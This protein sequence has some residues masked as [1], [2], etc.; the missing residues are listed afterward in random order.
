MRYISHTALGA[1]L[2]L[3]AGIL[4]LTSTHAET[5]GAMKPSSYAGSPPFKRSAAASESSPTASATKVVVAGAPGKQ[6]PF[7]RGQR[8]ISADNANTVEFA[9]FEETTE[10]SGP[11]SRPWI[12]AP[13]KKRRPLYQR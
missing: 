2:F 5:E 9:R 12:G 8:I 1:A 11:P 13:G 7:K 6:G 10:A 3:C 4:P